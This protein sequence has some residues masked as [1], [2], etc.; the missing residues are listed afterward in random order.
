MTT[1]TKLV[2][3]RIREHYT[4]QNGE[5]LVEKGKVKEAKLLKEACLTIEKLRS[6]HS[7]LQQEKHSKHWENYDLRKEL[8]QREKELEEREARLQERLE[9]LAGDIA[10]WTKQIPIA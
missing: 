3:E 4:A 1:N 2:E 6:S 10:R 8:D 5:W 9:H 7:K